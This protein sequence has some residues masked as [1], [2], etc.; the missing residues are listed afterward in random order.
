M[1]HCVESIEVLH[2][3]DLSSSEN[4]THTLYSDFSGRF[5]CFIPFLLDRGE[6][7][8]GM[9]FPSLGGGISFKFPGH[10]DRYYIKGVKLLLMS[11]SVLLYE[12]D[13]ESCGESRAT[14][15]GPWNLVSIV[16]RP[17]DPVS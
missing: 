13:R 1:L 6:N 16:M 2:E 11:E 5:F 4:T 3:L 14:R 17:N 12:E 10:F 15:C 7:V 9:V 8:L